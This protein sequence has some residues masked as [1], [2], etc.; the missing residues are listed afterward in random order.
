M[1]YEG[2]VLNMDV[3][4]YVCTFFPSNIELSSQ[5]MLIIF[6]VSFWCSIDVCSCLWNFNLFFSC[7]ILTIVQNK[8]TTNCFVVLPIFNILH[9]NGIKVKNIDSIA[10]HY[11][12][13]SLNKKYFLFQNSPHFFLFFPMTPNKDW[14]QKYT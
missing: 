14:S 8:K 7:Y 3:L 1:I 11:M 6:I 12:W 9:I 13:C 4:K 5:K 10:F 2:R